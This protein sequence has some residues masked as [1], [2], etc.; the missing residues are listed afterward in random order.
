MVQGG[1]RWIEEIEGLRRWIRNTDFVWNKPW[2]SAD[3]Q[4]VHLVRKVGWSGLVNCSCPVGVHRYEHRQS[5]WF[6]DIVHNMSSS[7]TDPADKVLSPH[8]FLFRF[9]YIEQSLALHRASWGN[10]VRI[11]IYGA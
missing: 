4:R 11:L 8:C 5:F 3:R 6:A 10:I 2:L 1:N 7:S 9:F